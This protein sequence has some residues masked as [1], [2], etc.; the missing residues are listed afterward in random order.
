MLKHLRQ[1]KSDIL[2]IVKDY[3]EVPDRISSLFDR[4]TAS[5][6]SANVSRH[7]RPSAAPP[8]RGGVHDQAGDDVHALHD[9][10]RGVIG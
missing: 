2:D 4:L 10:G 7:V 8:P 6:P 1:L 9:G 5:L 3:P